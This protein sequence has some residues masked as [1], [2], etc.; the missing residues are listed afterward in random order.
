MNLKSLQTPATDDSKVIYFGFSVLILVFVIFGGWMAFAPLVA[1]SVA[2]GTVSADLNKKT[3]QHLEGGKVSA[4]Y[5]KDGDKVSKGQ[6]LLKLNDIQI[7]ANLDILSSQYQETLAMY[8]RLE[9]Q[10]ENK[11]NI[12]FP[13]ELT[14]KK[15]IKDQE[16]IF[17]T[18]KRKQ[19]DEELVAQKKI[20]QIKNQIDGLKSIQKSKL[21]RVESLKEEVKEWESLYKEKLTDKQKIRELKRE[22][23]KLNGEI[24]NSNSDI[25]RLKEQIKEINTNLRLQKETFEKET[26]EQFVKTKTNL[27]DLKSKIQATQDTLNRTNIKSPIDGIVVGMQIHTVGAVIKPGEKLMDIVPLNAKLVVVAKVNTTDIDKVKPGLEADLLFPAFNM[28]KLHVI[29]GRVIHVSADSF[30]DEQKG[31]SY[32]EAKIEITKEGM[33]ELKKNNFILIPGMPAQAMIHI[34]DRTLLSYLL[35]PFSLMLK[36]SFNE[37]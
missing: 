33:D 37:E 21:Q 24:E 1:S 34:G 36:R 2:S 22:I 13:P 35:K 5:V 19:Q 32:Y 15:A 17:Y 9:A 14:N 31:I 6:I 29:K 7:K 3:I 20:I 12:N 27:S 10:K 28:K 18:T 25:L 4:I 26:L 16:R 11:P 23:D 30:V 8:A